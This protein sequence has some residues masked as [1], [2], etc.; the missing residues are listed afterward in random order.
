[1]MKMW[2]LMII[3]KVVQPNQVL[4][5]IM[6]MTIMAWRHIPTMTNSHHGGKVSAK[7]VDINVV[8][9]DGVN[10]EDDDEDDDV[11]RT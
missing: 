3:N 7:D 5:L 9:D 10:Y 2:L 1:M 8:D 6:R 4:I 11:W